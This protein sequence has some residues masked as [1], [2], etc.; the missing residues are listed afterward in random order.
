M[1]KMSAEEFNE[2]RDGKTEEE[3]AGENLSAKNFLLN[4]SKELIQVPIDGPDGQMKIEIRA[5]LTKG[6]IRKH[7]DFLAIF[8]NP[9]EA[10]EKEADIVTAKFLAMIT[11]DSDLNEDFWSSEDIDSSIMQEL[12]VAFLE[13][14]ASTIKQNQKFRN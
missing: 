4:R 7:K 10:D 11:T 9:E 12:I 8:Q 6:E 14:A 1:S 5:R 2:R 13:K 3:F